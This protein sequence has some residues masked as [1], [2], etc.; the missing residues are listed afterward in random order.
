MPHIPDIGGTVIVG[1]VDRHNPRMKLGVRVLCAGE[2]YA[3]FPEVG[4]RLIDFAGVCDLLFGPR[5]LRD[6]THTFV[7]Q[8][9]KLVVG[10]GRIAAAQ[11]FYR[12]FGFGHPC[13]SL[14]HLEH[15]LF[16]HL[17]RLTGQGAVIVPDGCM[18]RND[19]RRTSAIGNHIMHPH[20]HRDM[21]PQI[22][23]PHI[24][25]LHRVERAAP[26]LRITGG[27]CGLAGEMVFH[28]VHPGAN[29]VGC[30]GIP[31]GMP[32]ERAVQLPECA[33][34]RHKPLAGQN[35]FGWA[36]VKDQGA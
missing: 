35:L 16:D 17:H 29:A 10:K 21:L 4:H 22:V 19:I 14:R 1:L 8:I 23:D 20:I 36:S 34:P 12:Q 9:G 24:H 32:C 33:C 30:A 13:G 25:Q 6:R 7:D 27:V 15:P 11:P 28:R 2:P 31:S 3:L 26:L 18:I 5:L